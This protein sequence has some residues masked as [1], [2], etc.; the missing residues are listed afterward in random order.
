MPLRCCWLVLLLLAGGCQS[1]TPTTAGDPLEPGV[2]GLNEVR[3]GFDRTGRFLTGKEQVSESRAREFYRRG[4][5]QF[6]AGR[7]LR[8]AEAT[9]AFYQAGKLFDRAAEAAP[10]SALQQDSLRMA[11]ESYFFANQLERAE[12]AFVKLQQEHPRSRHSEH[13]SQRLF[14]IGKY[15]IDA[16]IAREDEVVPVNFSDDSLPWMD[17]AG[18]GVRVLDQMRYDDPT[19][20][21]ADDSTMA[22]AVEKMR[23]QQWFEADMLFADL[24]EIYPDSDHQFNA[25]KLG[26]RCKLEMYAGPN[27]S[28]LALDDAQELIERTRRLFPEEMKD[29]ANREFFDNAEKTVRYLQAEK[30]WTRARYR[31][32]QRHFGGAAAYLQKILDQYPDTPFA[33]QAR[34]H[35]VA[36]ADKPQTPPQRLAFLA[37]L[38]P[39][40]RREKPLLGNDGSVLRR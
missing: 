19:S 18:H 26:L 24:R 13:A 23:Q 33:E 21:L 1:W 4:Y 40:A 30:L 7:R 29:P 35:L 32:K 10:G 16:G 15:W 2:P 28:G 5:E 14:A 12:D 37:R 39:D 31:E 17:S 34:E 22:I 6:E 27:Y 9:D 25:H 8:D 20:R 36:N 3:E 38:F 11:G